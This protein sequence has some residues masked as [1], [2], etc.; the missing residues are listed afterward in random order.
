[1][2]LKTK[3]KNDLLTALKSQDRNRVEVLRY[4]LSQIKDQE[5]AQEREELSDE[6]VI[7]LIR[8][9]IKKLKEGLNFFQQAK[10]QDLIEKNQKEI[11]ILSDYLPAEV[12]DEQLEK[13]VEKIISQNPN[14]TQ[15]GALIGICIK[16]LKEKADPRRISQLVM[17]RLAK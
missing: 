13:E 4:L 12:S 17:K 6:Q 1:M 14:I 16:A 2:N 10:R 8:G 15:P 3:I 5:I 7:S 11:E 9:Q